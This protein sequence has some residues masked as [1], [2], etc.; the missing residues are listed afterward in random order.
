V[1]KQFL[2][3]DKLPVSIEQY[4]LVAGVGFPTKVDEAEDTSTEQFRSGVLQN[5]VQ[6]PLIKPLG[7]ASRR[8]WLDSVDRYARDEFLLPVDKLALISILYIQALRRAH[9][10]NSAAFA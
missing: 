4:S 1:S 9:R 6:R 3:G 5:E 7:L 2:S 10:V 8:P